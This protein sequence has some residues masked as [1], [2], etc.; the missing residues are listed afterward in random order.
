VELF[1]PLVEHI[2]MAVVT[3]TTNNILRPVMLGARSKF[4]APNALTPLPS[5]VKQTLTLLV[6]S[7]C[8]MDPM[9]AS[10]EVIPFVALTTSDTH[11]SNY[12]ASSNDQKRKTK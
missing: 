1:S 3:T 12:N 11:L 9:S 5:V 6:S 4:S 10:S 7:I 2:G 8:S